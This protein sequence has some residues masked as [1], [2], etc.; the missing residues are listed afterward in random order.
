ML[1]EDVIMICSDKLLTK[2]KNV[3]NITKSSHQR[4]I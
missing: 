2:Y 3:E 1:Y 4:N